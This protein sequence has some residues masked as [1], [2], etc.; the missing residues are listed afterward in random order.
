LFGNAE[1]CSAPVCDLSSPSVGGFLGG[2][3]RLLPKKPRTRG[4][5]LKPVIV[6][7]RLGEGGSRSFYF[8]SLLY[9]SAFA[10]RHHSPWHFDLPLANIAA[11]KN[12]AG[13]ARRI[14]SWRRRSSARFSSLNRRG[15]SSTFERSLLCARSQ[16]GHRQP[17]W[18]RQLGGADQTAAASAA[19]RVRGSPESRPVSTSL[20][21]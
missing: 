14:R 13:S 18:S 9:L 8:Q 17:A 20:T 19:R 11:E 2:H 16:C 12:G 21:T 6:G 10:P 7:G 15:V 4:A 3:Q 1:N 5:S